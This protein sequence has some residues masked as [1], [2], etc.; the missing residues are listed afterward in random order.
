MVITAVSA[1][2][3]GDFSALFGQTFGK[4]FH[5]RSFTGSAAGQIADADDE[6]S[7][8]VMA[9]DPAVIEPEAEFCDIAEKA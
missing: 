5:H 2:Q 1:A 8:G 4:N 6:T 3:D 7:Q 9:D